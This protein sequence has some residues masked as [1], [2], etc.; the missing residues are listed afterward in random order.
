MKRHGQG[1]RFPLALSLSANYADE[2]AGVEAALP[3]PLEKDT[4]VLLMVKWRGG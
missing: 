1:R 2:M 4:N 3:Q